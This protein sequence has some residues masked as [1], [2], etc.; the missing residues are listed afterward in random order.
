MS[1][2]ASTVK[3]KTSDVGGGFWF[4]DDFHFIVIETFC[5]SQSVVSSTLRRMIVGWDGSD[6][7]DGAPPGCLVGIVGDILAKCRPTQHTLAFWKDTPNQPTSWQWWRWV[8]V[9]TR[10][11]N[12]HGTQINCLSGVGNITTTIIFCQHLMS[13]GTRTWT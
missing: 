5:K 8:H 12:V 6:V 4:L 13:C 9:L 10:V 3:L 11:G 7:D 2:I 1:W